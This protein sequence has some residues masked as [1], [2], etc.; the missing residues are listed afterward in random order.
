MYIVKLT[1]NYDWPIFRQTPQNL[2]VWG[3]YMFVIDS[4]LKECDYWIIYTE[5]KLIEEQCICN[6]ENIFFIPGE[7]VNTCVKY[8][9]EFL[10]QFGKIITV[11]REIK[12]KNVIH[13]QGANPWF[14]EKSYDELNNKANVVKT[15]LM[16]IISS[17][18]AFTQG[19]VKRLEFA[20]RIKEH[21]GDAVDFYGRGLNPF[22]RKWDTLAPYKY[23]ISIE[24][25]YC[26]DY[27]TEKFFDPIFANSYPFYYGCPNL[28]EYVS[29]ESFTR[30][31]INNFDNSV[32]IIDNIIKSDDIYNEFHNNC[33]KYKEELLNKHQFFPMLC[34]FMDG[35]FPNVAKK[36]IV[37]RGVENVKKNSHNEIQK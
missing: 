9:K 29:K 3:D 27:F 37:M 4:N 32:S 18:K 10:S 36:R 11:Q 6:R 1:F 15:K 28:E 7:G 16:S 24:N 23:H 30:I 22:D 35:S 19:H 34:K 14:V 31:D 5:Y 33:Y 17:D 21:Y 20:K 8:P 12:G 25:D 13:Y 26:D 2:G